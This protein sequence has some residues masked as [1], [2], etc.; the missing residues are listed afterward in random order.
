MKFYIKQ[1]ILSFRDKFRI[2]DESQKEVYTVEGKFFSIQNKLELL[3]ANGSQ[4]LNAKK[5]LFRFFATYEIFTPHGELTAVVKRKLSIRPKFELEVQGEVLTVEGSLFAHSFGIIKD[6]QEV[7]SIHKKV[8][9]WGDTYEIDID[10]NINIELYLFMVI[11]IDQVIHEKK[12]NNG[13]NF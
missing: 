3:N 11:I 7:A 5:K 10:S 12:K 8:I 1:K 6:G 4:V 2:M 9:S 13:T